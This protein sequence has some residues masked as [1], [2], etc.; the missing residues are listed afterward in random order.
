REEQFG[1]LRDAQ[2]K[3][4]DLRHWHQF[5]STLIGGGFRSSDM[6]SSQNALLYAYAFYLLGRDRCG[7]PGHQLQK[8]IGRWF[9]FSTL[10]GRYTSSPEP[11]MAGALNRLKGVSA[12]AEFLVVLTDVMAS[13]LTNV[14]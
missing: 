1:V 4:L 6:V 14:F 11:G 7:V 13:D 12:P 3:V 2:A 9:F 10:T 5:M 8:A